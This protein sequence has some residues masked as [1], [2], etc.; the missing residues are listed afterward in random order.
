TL[1]SGPGIVVGRDLNLFNVGT[2]LDLSNGANLTIGRFFGAV[3][4]PPKGTGTG[5]NLLAQNQSL[6]GTTSA[7]STS[8]AGYIQGNFNL[9]PGSSFTVGQGF[10]TTLITTTSTATTETLAVPSVLL[11]NGTVTA[12]STSQFIVPSPGVL[13]GSGDRTLTLSTL[14]GSGANFVA[15]AGFNIPGIPPFPTTPIPFP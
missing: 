8:L 13:V 2:D 9:G 6:V 10:G 15:R 11:V 12:S 5:S 3:A 4:Q 7:I 1:N 14:P